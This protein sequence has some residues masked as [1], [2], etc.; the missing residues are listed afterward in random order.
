MLIY[1]RTTQMPN[2]AKWIL[3]LRQTTRS[4]F[5]TIGVFILAGICTLHA[6][7]ETHTNVHTAQCT[8]PAPLCS[9]VKYIKIVKYSV[10][11]VEW[12][13]S[14]M[15]TDLYAHLLSRNCGEETI[16][17]AFGFFFLL[18]LRRLFLLCGTYF[19][20]FLQLMK[21]EN[22]NDTNRTHSIDGY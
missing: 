6:A 13:S 17:T 22:G 9:R 7:D 4:T 20:L 10:E 3:S 5:T 18:S 8:P 21:K 2:N 1:V 19:I 16:Q 12:L 15:L 11:P 14:V